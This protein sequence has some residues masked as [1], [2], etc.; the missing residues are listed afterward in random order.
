MFP[1]GRMGS[2][3]SRK[4][5]RNWNSLRE[6]KTVSWHTS[7]EEISFLPSL[8]LIPVKGKKRILLLDIEGSGCEKRSPSPIYLWTCFYINLVFPHF[9]CLMKNLASLNQ[10][11]LNQIWH[12][13]GPLLASKGGIFWW[14]EIGEELVNLW[15]LQLINSGFWV[16]IAVWEELKIVIQECGRI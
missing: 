13:D 16:K 1:F 11:S 3:K 2:S 14:W 7:M 4:K 6:R 12:K 9:S 15:H 8:L 5:M 10:N